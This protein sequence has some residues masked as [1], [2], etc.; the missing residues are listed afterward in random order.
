MQLGLDGMLI[1]GGYH[2]PSTATLTKFRKAISEEHNAKR[3]DE[4]K[5]RLTGGGFTL[6]G[7]ELAFMKRETRGAWMSS[8]ECSRRLEAAWRQLAPWNEWL[9]TTVGPPDGVA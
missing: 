6:E 8:R 4:L 9:H 3:F 1:G 2:E 7:N 5:A